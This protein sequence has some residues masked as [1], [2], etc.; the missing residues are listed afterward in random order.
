MKEFNKALKE[1]YDSVKR[2]KFS[3]AVALF[4]KVDYIW[5]NLPEIR[6]TKKLKE[7][8]QLMHEELYL[9]LRVN[10]AY[11]MAE[12]GDLQGLRDELDHIYSR[13]Y[14]DSFPVRLKPLEDFITQNYKFCLEVYRYKLGKRT[15]EN[16]H[17]KIKAL[18][19]SHRADKALKHYS[20]L[21]VIYN[22]LHNYLGKDEKEDYYNKLK[23]LY[24]D[25]SLAKLM[26]VAVNKQPIL[27]V[28]K[29]KV[30]VIEKNRVRNNVPKDQFS[31]VREYIEK[32]SV[33]EASDVLD[34]I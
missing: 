23:G 17:Q 3:H 18:A 6:K 31:K 8:I 34:C 26:H 4:S 30:N 27:K 22:K 25:I 11:L 7:E 10:E 16:I 21:V 29:Q 15:F 19:T 32:G 33:A 14:E 9:Y 2:K 28:T 20:D 24:T 13:L 1:V 12:K 5:D